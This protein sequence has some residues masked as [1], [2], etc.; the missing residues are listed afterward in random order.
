MAMAATAGEPVRAPIRAITPRRGLPSGRAIVGALLVTIAAVGAFIAATVGDDTPDTAYLVLNEPIAAGA[1]VSVDM[2]EAVPMELSPSVAESSLVSTVGLDGAVALRDLRAGE[3]LSAADLI[4]TPV[5]DGEPI[6]SVHELTFGIPLDRTP[7]GILRG[8]RVTV[9][10]TIDTQTQVAIE[11]ALVLAID[12]EP[13]SIGASGRGVL[14]LAIDDPADVVAVA[15]LTQV[16]D[17]TVVR[18]T[19]AIE[20]VFPSG[21]EAEPD[22]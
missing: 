14:T 6:G 12:T 20:D 13:D 17:I 15:H 19:R 22:S 1:A 11:D 10:A 21:V 2:V 7:A 3:L 5:V 9:L 16:A 18:S 4:A 8:D